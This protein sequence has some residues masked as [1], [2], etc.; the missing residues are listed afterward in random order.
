MFFSD[1]DSTRDAIRVFYYGGD[2]NDAIRGFRVL[3]HSIRR[4]D[5][6]LGFFLARKVGQLA[7]S[8]FLPFS[9]RNKIIGVCVLSLIHI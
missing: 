8:L 1:G 5:L 7:L 2:Q 6:D 3:K 9:G 4:G